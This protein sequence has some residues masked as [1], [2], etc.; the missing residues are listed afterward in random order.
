MSTKTDILLRRLD[1][2]H[3]VCTT[4]PEHVDTMFSEAVQTISAL[5]AETPS[6]IVEGRTEAEDLS[7][8]S[9]FITPGG[10]AFRQRRN[11]YFEGDL[12]WARDGHDPI[13]TDSLDEEAH[14]PGIVV[15][16]G[17]EDERTPRFQR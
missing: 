6:R 3:A 15:Y 7:E 11:W 14:F 2:A 10:I 12:V 8:S 5:K 4:A 17:Y 1:R 13:Q 9:I 16:L